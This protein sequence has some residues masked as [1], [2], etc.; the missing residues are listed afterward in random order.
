M[1]ENILK[2][3]KLFKSFLSVS[4][5]QIFSNQTMKLLLFEISEQNLDSLTTFKSQDR[6]QDS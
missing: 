6:H 4:S 2:L 3:W 1:T 5:K